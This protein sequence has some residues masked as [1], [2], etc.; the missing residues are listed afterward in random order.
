MTVKFK[1]NIQFH[2]L[3]NHVLTKKK[4]LYGSHSQ[5]ISLRKTSV[6]E[7]DERVHH[8]VSCV[9]IVLYVTSCDKTTHIIH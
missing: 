5:M 7:M 8:C 4:M 1:Q 6:Q 2:F 9:P 3:R